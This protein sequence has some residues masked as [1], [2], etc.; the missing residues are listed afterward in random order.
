MATADDQAPRDITR[1]EG[2][3]ASTAFCRSQHPYTGSSHRELS[4]AISSR[5]RRIFLCR[6]RSRGPPQCGAHSSCCCQTVPPALNSPESFLG[7]PVS[8]STYLNQVCPHPGLDLHRF[9]PQDP[10]AVSL[11]VSP[12]PRPCRG[13]LSRSLHVVGPAA[14]SWLLSHLSTAIARQLPLLPCPS[15]LPQPNPCFVCSE[16]LAWA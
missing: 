1:G 2:K 14:L 7:A 9:T 4:C 6:Q 13:L 11:L 8:P 3:C 12:P 15:V 10:W 16:A 5:P